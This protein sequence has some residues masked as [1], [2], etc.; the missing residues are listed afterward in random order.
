MSQMVRNVAYNR[1]KLLATTRK[2]PMKGVRNFYIALRDCKR[3]NVSAIWLA[4]ALIA[5]DWSIN[6]LIT[7]KYSILFLYKY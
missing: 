2:T 1:N 6:K 3:A 7:N 4:L 5:F